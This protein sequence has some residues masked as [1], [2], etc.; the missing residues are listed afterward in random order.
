MG[1]LSWAERVNSPFI[2]LF[3]PFLALNGLDGTHP[4]WGGQSAYSAIQILI[5]SR[6]I[7]TDTPRNKCLAKICAPHGHT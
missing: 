2:H 5:F 6:N 7:F 1:Q 3:A 4:H